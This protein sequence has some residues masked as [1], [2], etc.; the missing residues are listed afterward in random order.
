MYAKDPYEE[1]YQLLIDKTESGRLKHLNDS[2]A[3]IETKIMWMIFIKI[4]KNIIQTRKIKYWLYLMIW[5]L[6]GLVIKKRNP[7]VP[8]LF[9][10]GRKLNISLVFIT[11]SYLD[12]PKNVR[13]HPTHY[14]YQEMPNKQELQQMAFNHLSDIDF[15]DVMNLYKK[16]TAKPYFFSFWCCSGIR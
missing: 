13:L 4:L 6:I 15:Q 11:Q 16:C 5:L 8:E 10:R 9:I 2:K 12:I 1:K 14:F 3:F 7:V